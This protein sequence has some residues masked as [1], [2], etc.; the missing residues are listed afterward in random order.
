MIIVGG[1]KRK[2][3]VRRMKKN[4]PKIF[5]CPNCG[6][7]TLAIEINREAGIAEAKCGKCK[8]NYSLEISSVEHAVDAYG[9]F[10]DKYYSG[11]KEDRNDQS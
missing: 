3:V 7:K 10:I 6:E 5:S 4:I 2:K 8:I 9:K 11:E 1:R